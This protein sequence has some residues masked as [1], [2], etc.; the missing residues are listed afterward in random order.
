MR[1]VTMSHASGS[2]P[3]SAPSSQ[4]N[5]P[6]GTDAASTA[7]TART[8]P[9]TCTHTPRLPRTPKASISVP[10]P[11]TVTVNSLQKLDKVHKRTCSA[12][13]TEKQVN[14]SGKLSS[15]E[16]PTAKRKHNSV[17]VSAPPYTPCPLNS[18]ETVGTS[19]ILPDIVHIIWRSSLLMV[20]LTLFAVGLQMH[21]MMIVIF[22]K[23]AY[24]ISVSTSLVLLVPCIVALVWNDDDV[25][26]IGV[27]RWVWATCSA[28]TLFTAAFVTA[29]WVG[30]VASAPDMFSRGFQEGHW[31]LSFMFQME[32]LLDEVQVTMSHAL[33]VF[34]LAMLYTIAVGLKIC[35]PMWLL[36]V[37]QQRPYGFLKVIVTFGLTLAVFYWLIKARTAFSDSVKRHRESVPAV[38][39][40]LPQ[41]HSVIVTPCSNMHIAQRASKSWLAWPANPFF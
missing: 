18:W 28:M 25:L 8:V 41:N 20:T 36:K 31:I 24:I 34:V 9:S 16:I 27:I 17:E 14:L 30:Y 23:D 26:D 1:M 10:V 7:D 12:S 29:L 6:P 3:A 32:L 37:L 22:S 39:V 33:F 4:E 13:H 35:G 2:S 5:T 19:W 21:P 40:V 15:S 11:A 38:Q